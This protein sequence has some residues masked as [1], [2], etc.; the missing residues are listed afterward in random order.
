MQEEN[1]SCR[2]CSCCRC[3]GCIGPRLFEIFIGNKV[4]DL[5]DE[6]V[7][8]KIQHDSTQ[9]HN[10]EGNK[11]VGNAGGNDE[12]KVAVRDHGH[13]SSGMFLSHELSLDVGQEWFPIEAV[14]TNFEKDTCQNTLRNFGHQ[15]LESCHLNDGEQARK[16]SSHACHCTFI[17]NEDG[18]NS[19]LSTRNATA[20]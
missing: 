20:H 6:V 16:D 17:Q 13:S 7:H 1:P 11:A 19:R 10:V 8:H 15:A 9:D 18:T 4:W 2:R 3:I 12:N 5:H 14:V